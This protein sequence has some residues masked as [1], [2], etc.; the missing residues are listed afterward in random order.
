MPRKPRKL[1]SSGIYHVMLRGIN[2]QSIFADDDDNQKFLFLLKD[3]KKLSSFE[4]YGYCLMSNHVHLLIKENNEA[5]GQIIKRIASRYVFWFN[6]KYSRCGHLFQERY[7]S[8]PVENDQSFIYVLRYIHQNPLKANICKSIN[9]YKWC[10]Y[11]E[12]ITHKNIVNIELALSLI[13][14]SEFIKFMN[15]SCDGIFLDD[16]SPRKN[17]SDNNV[18]EIIEKQLKTKVFMI[19]NESKDEIKRLC[20]KILKI[21]GI[22][23]RQLARITGVS[24]SIIW[25][26]N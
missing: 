4:L 22:T 18:I 6:K 19:Q 21:D 20:K 7:K 16:N 10:S 9:D 24:T 2:K 8:E 14:S 17:L 13:T 5:V 12:Y 11:H 23:T 26:L 3:I 15:E 1:S 25:N